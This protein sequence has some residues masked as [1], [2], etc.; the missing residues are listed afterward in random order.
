LDTDALGGLAGP[1]VDIAKEM[2]GS[3]VED[4]PGMEILD[5]D[6]GQALLGALTGMIEGA[7]GD[8]ADSTGLPISDIVSETADYTQ[9]MMDMAGLDSDVAE[10]ILSTLLQTGS[11]AAASKLSDVLGAQVRV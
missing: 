6:A 8:I 2:V 10:D 7:V 4:L 9:S 1:I 3:A 5:S 11:M